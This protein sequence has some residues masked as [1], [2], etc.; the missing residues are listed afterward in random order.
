[1]NRSPRPSRPTSNLSASVNRRL[2]AYA[3]AAGASGVGMLALAQP[4][5]ARIV[6]TRAH[7]TVPINTPFPLDLNHDRVND[8]SFVLN[9]TGESSWLSAYNLGSNGIVGQMPNR[10]FASALERGAHIG[11]GRKFL[12]GSRPDV[13]RGY[14]ASTGG[15]GSTGKWGNAHNRY[16]GVK[17]SIKGK[18]H[19]GWVRL[20]VSR[21]SGI[22]A[23]ITGYA[24]ETIPNKTIIAGHIKARNE[25]SAIE[26]ANPTALPAPT[27]KPVSLGLLAIGAPGLSIWRREEVTEILGY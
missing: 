8:L 15:G 25:V 17:F 27:R 22:D 10:R 6:Y 2:N 13:L 4:A 12:T 7:I 5:E 14:W 1:M 24:Y 19:Y 20:S 23:L 18:T 26:Q 3:L 9:E 16:L 11:A 21:P